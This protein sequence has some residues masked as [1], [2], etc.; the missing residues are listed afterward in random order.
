MALKSYQSLSSSSSSKL[1]LLTCLYFLTRKSKLANSNPRKFI[2]INP[3]LDRD[4]SH[5]NKHAPTQWH[6]LTTHTP[7]ALPS[8]PPSLHETQP[9]NTHSQVAYIDFH[10]F[11]CMT[12]NRKNLQYSS[13]YFLNSSCSPHKNINSELPIVFRRTKGTAA[14]RNDHQWK[15]LRTQ[16][17]EGRFID[18]SLNIFQSQLSFSFVEHIYT[19]LHTWTLSLSIVL[20]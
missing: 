19:F 20:G 10:V 2:K 11:S 4:K 13:F 18:S 16:R 1:C 15:L 14:Q 12:T 8:F 9:Q 5:W 17:G 6:P 3:H 7:M